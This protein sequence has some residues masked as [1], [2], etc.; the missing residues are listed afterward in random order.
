MAIAAKLENKKVG[1]IFIIIFAVW[2][3]FSIV[4]TCLNFYD[5]E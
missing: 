4:F 2:I 1:I 3:V 5:Y